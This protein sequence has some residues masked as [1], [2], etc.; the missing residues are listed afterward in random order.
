M[1]TLGYI[2]YGV[3]LVGFTLWAMRNADKYGRNY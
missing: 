2:V 1:E 3:G